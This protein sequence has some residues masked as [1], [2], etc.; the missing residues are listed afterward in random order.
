MK[1]T[2]A[3]AA[4]AC[5]LIAGLAW[6]PTSS[7]LSTGNVTTTG[8]I[9]A[10]GTVQGADVAA[11]DDGTITDDLYAG[12]N[13][14]IEGDTSLEGDTTTTGSLSIGAGDPIFVMG[15]TSGTIAASA[16]TCTTI[17]SGVDAS[18]VTVRTDGWASLA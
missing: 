2:I 11:T 13:L 7:D 9:T 3:A 6:T 18:T 17:A 8:N 14:N 1:Q 12:G 5:L 10:T 4:F 16:S 15:F